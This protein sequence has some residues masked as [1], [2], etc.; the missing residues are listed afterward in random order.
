MNLLRLPCHAA[1]GSRDENGI[2]ARGEQDQRRKEG[3]AFGGLLHRRRLVAIVHRPNSDTLTTWAL[4]HESSIGREDEEIP[5]AIARI[6]LW[7]RRPSAPKAQ[8]H[9]ARACRCSRICELAPSFSSYAADSLT[10][11]RRAA[12]DYCP[13]TAIAGGGPS[14]R[15]ALPSLGRTPHHHPLLRFGT[16]VL[17]APA[18][19]DPT[20][21]ARSAT[22]RQSARR[23]HL[24][25]P[26]TTRCHLGSNL[27]IARGMRSLCPH[28][29]PG[30]ETLRSR[31]RKRSG[32][33]IAVTAGH[34]CHQLVSSGLPSV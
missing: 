15:V 13:Q 27:P 20:P 16:L 26:L 2:H 6:P 4:P 8:L 33:E 28:S 3:C 11:S 23:P 12:H 9:L 34:S 18:S 5:Q 24:H 17:A 25:P 30:N 31:F 21:P 22:P 14:S 32:A 10:K 19:F 1:P 29:H 7:F